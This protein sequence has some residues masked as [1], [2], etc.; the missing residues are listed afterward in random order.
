MVVISILFGVEMSMK[1]G[2]GSMKLRSVDADD[3]RVAC[4]ELKEL[5]KKHTNNNDSQE[6]N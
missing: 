6:R 1:V 5:E 4:G 2:D 3:G